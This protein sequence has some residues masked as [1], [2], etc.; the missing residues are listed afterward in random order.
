MSRPCA[1]ATAGLVALVLAFVVA[2]AAH[3]QAASPQSIFP[4]VPFVAG[5]PV[6]HQPELAYPLEAQQRARE[7]KVV[8][9]FL[10]GVD[11]VPERFRI[12]ESDPPVLFDR[13]VAD[14]AP[15][16]RFA[17]AMRDG[18]AVRYE[19]HLTLAFNPQRSPRKE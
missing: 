18:S 13:T 6:M 16:F 2:G 7:G 4:G 1:C 8:I 5:A 10:V 12:L 3:A 15:E 17:V 14:A 9:A 11:G 19:T